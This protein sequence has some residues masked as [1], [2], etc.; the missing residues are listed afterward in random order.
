MVEDL[1]YGIE[2]VGVHLQAD[3]PEGVRVHGGNAGHGLVLEIVGDPRFLEQVFYN[4][5]LVRVGK[6]C[7]GNKVV[8]IRGII[9]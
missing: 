2:V 4:G 3:A 5:D 7:G 9:A 6:D 8:H 1:F